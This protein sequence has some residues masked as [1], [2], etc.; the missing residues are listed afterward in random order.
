MKM[1]LL[2]SIILVSSVL[3]TGIWERRC[4]REI[5]KCHSKILKNC[6]FNNDHDCY[7]HNKEKLLDC[8]HDLEICQ[9]I[10]GFAYDLESFC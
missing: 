7:C 10:P 3:S 9:K 1:L 6:F 4:K 2:S 5:Y 8:V